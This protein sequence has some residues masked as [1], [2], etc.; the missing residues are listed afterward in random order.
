MRDPHDVL[1]LGDLER[2]PRSRVNVRAHYDGVVI[3]PA[4]EAAALQVEPVSL[5]VVEMPV[6]VVDGCVGQEGVE[7]GL[8]VRGGGE[9]DA[10]EGQLD[11][12]ER[13]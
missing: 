5:E 3:Y 6:A 1:L 9:Q 11:G 13:R 8:D 2:E 7:H 10:V 12:A 4:G